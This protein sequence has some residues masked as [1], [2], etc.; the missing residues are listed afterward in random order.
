M[1]YLK[2]FAIFLLLLTISVVMTYPLITVLGERVPSGSGGDVWVHLWTFDWLAEAA[3]TGQN[4]LHT[5]RIFYPDGASLATHNTAWLNF[6]LWWPFRQITNIWAA[7]SLMQI[8][9]FA[10]NGLAGYLL[11]RELAYKT[12]LALLGSIIIGFF[13]FTL[14]RYGQPNLALIATVPLAMLFIHR[15]LHKQRWRDAVWAGV[16]VGLIGVS[17]WALL[18]VAIIPIC[19]AGVQWLLRYPLDKK[20]VTQ[21]AVA[22]CFAV[23]VMLPFA[24][25]VLNATV[26]TDAPGK[27]AVTAAQDDDRPTNPLAWIIPN[28]HQT[29]YQPL[30][31]AIPEPYQ[32]D[33]NRVEFIG[34][35]TLLLALIGFVSRPR[36]T[37][38]A[39]A[40]VLTLMLL[41]I[42]TNSPL[43]RLFTSSVLAELMRYAYRFNAVLSIPLA[44]LA[45]N[46]AQA[47]TRRTKKM[48]IVPLLA[49]LVLI[50]AAVM[51]YGTRDPITP[52]WLHTLAADPADYAMLQLPLNAN[53]VDKAF[54]MYQ[55]THRKKL[56]GGHVSRRTADMYVYQQQSSF[57][58]WLLDP[59]LPITAAQVQQGYADLAADH[60]CYIVVHRFAPAVLLDLWQAQLGT[61]HH[62]DDELLIYKTADQCT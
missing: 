38:W 5:T 8:T 55:I 57:I 52:Q 58:Q 33:G 53:S 30:A 43:Y 36:R 17:R 2:L 50:E 54:M 44:V 56:L 35:T 11:L 41:A 59:S 37:G 40:A 45:V 49:G 3:A 31:N 7:Y 9:I 1:R 13:P 42:G 51:P 39:M 61:P 48:W 18:T 62:Q 22:L 27:T 25:P 29:A 28:T 20:T 21:T 32:Q 26:L 4:P 23:L 6:L 12:T 24:L 14:S 47:I 15:T 60:V 46:G 34:Y 16:C 19:T 10:L